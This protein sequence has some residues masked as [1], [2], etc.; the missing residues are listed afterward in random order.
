MH[1][2]LFHLG[3]FTVS[4]Y[5]VALVI[6]FA[7]AT[8]LTVRADRGRAPALCVLP[9]ERVVDLLSWSLLGGIVGGRLFYVVLHWPSFAASPL[10]VAAI[11][12]GG[13]VWYG[14]LLGGLLAGW[15]YAMTARVSFLRVVDRAI[16]FVALGHAIGRIGC[17]LNGCCYGKP[18]QVWCGVVFPGTTTPVWP[19]QL[20]EAGGLGL[21]SLILR[22]LQR[23]AWLERPG[24]LT[25]IYLIG[26][27]GL[28]M[29]VEFLRGDQPVWWAGLTLQQLISVG[30]LGL[31]LVLW[32]GRRM[33]LR[34]G[35]AA[36]SWRART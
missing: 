4:S 15:V 32:G 22:R 34:A 3:P 25:G 29:G 17:W 5:G 9:P 2:V 21:L 7:A 14:G 27:A 16:P 20:I 31:G 26:Y 33:N 23:P 18:T 13:L 1:P 6:G 8:W 19:T 30:V 11:W 24:R 35:P 28:R 12:H 36:R 10:E